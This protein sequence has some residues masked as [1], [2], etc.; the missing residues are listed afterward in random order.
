VRVIRFDDIKPARTTLNSTFE[1]IGLDPEERVYATLCNERASNGNCY[2]FRWDPKTGN[3]KYLGSL[4]QS[5]KRAGNIGPNQYWPKKEVI[6]KGHTHNVYLDGQIWMGTMNVH[7][8]KNI[9]EHR[10]IHIFGY[11]LATGVLTDHSQWQPK[12]V[13]KQHSGMYA[14]DAYPEKN[15]LVGIGPVDC[16]IITYNPRT[17]TTTKIPGVPKEDNPQLS[18]RDMTIVGGKVIYQCGSAKTPI[19]IYDLNTGQNKSVDFPGSV[20]LTLGYVPTKDEKKVYIS[21]Q[22]TIY[23]FNI[24]TEK[25]RTVATFD[26][27][28]TPRQVSPPALSRDEKKLYYVINMVGVSDSAFI[29]DL[30]EYHLET[31]VRTKLMNLKSVLDGGAKVSGAKSTASNDKIYFVFNANRVGIL[32]VDVS[33]RTGPARDDGEMATP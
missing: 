12:G 5:A 14:L 20:V 18:G 26:P 19:G 2:L 27:A 10:G 1:A 21:D 32:E 31:G 6:V 33:G 22:K 29:D 11:D 23:E 15:L 8:Y 25:F 9:A 4:V 30:Y 17:R 7:G 3:R 13:F 24:Q 16:E 28:G